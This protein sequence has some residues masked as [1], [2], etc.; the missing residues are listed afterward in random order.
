MAAAEALSVE[1]LLAPPPV[2]ALAR[3]VAPPG[4]LAVPEVEV[5]PGA[6]AVPEVAAALDDGPPA[7]GRLPGGGAWKRL[8]W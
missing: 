5:A 7:V 6:L 4:A 1:V 3:P 8:G 2:V